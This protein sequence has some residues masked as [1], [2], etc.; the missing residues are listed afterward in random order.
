[1]EPI[2]AS[3]T[4]GQ[5]FFILIVH[6]WQM[7]SGYEIFD[8][9]PVFSTLTGWHRI[10]VDLPGMGASPAGN[11][12]SLDDIFLRLVR[13]VDTT[14]A[15]SRFLIIGTSM[16]GYLGRALA[17]RYSQQVD[18]LLLRVPLIQPI[19]RDVDPCQPLLLDPVTM[20]AL[21]EAQRAL[22]STVLVQTPDY[23]S[24]LQD[25]IHHAVLPA[26]KAANIVVLERIRSNK[27]NYGLSPQYAPS[28]KRFEAPTLILTA[29]Q[30]ETVGYRDSL[31]LLELYPRSTFAVLD[32]ETHVMP[33]EDRAVFDALVKDWISRTLEWQGMTSMTGRPA[34]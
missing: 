26:L 27:Q 25:K 21:P 16:G 17:S 22:L 18:G 1:M 13:F 3:K 24:S 34:K 9:E 2:L 29:R 23:I 32:R 19:D 31:S 20:V 14:L 6:G 12:Q 11:I 8:F 30:D 4:F 5:G 10:Y 33:L 15:K 7:D 28:D